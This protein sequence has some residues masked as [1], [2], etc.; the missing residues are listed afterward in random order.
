MKNTLYILLF[1]I[2][3]VNAA[4]TFESNYQEQSAVLKRLDI[5]PSFLYDKALIETMDSYRETYKNR[6]FFKAM[7]EAYLYIPLIKQHLNG[8]ELP[9]EFLFLAMA[10]SNFA[11]EAYSHKKAAGLWQF[12]PRT[13][14]HYGL[15]IDDYVDERRDLVKSTDA[16][17]RYLNHLHNRFGKWYLAAMAYNCGG[18]RLQSA[19]KR[20]GSD[21]LTTL[22]DPKKRYLPKETRIYIRK[23]VALAIMGNDENYL[24]SKEY[25]FLLNRAD[26]FS[27]V[28]VDIPSGERLSRLAKIL[29]LPRNELKKYNP[30]LNYDFVPPYGKK[31]T[32]YIPY[33]KLSEFRRNYKPEPLQNIYLLYTVKAGDT[34]SQIGKKYR[35]SYKKIMDFNQLRSSRLSLKQKLIIPIDK[36]SLGNDSRYIVRDGDTLISI[37]KTFDISVKE[38]KAMNNID[39]SLIRI[40]DRLHVFN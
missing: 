5:D 20:A 11:I 31:Y 1:L 14:K 24:I 38:L 13:A 21:E 39:G 36:P 3:S 30:H 9:S 40:G 25:D 4:L 16:A 18:G 27:I 8:S 23:I 15:Q 7:D 33:V 29:N 22:L 28:S 10:E 26:A 34:L 19:I 32:I 6:H 35:I 37:A 2:S 12:M 17:V